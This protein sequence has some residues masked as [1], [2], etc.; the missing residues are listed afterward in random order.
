M[1]DVITTQP[2]A[3]PRSDS[4]SSGE[5]HQVLTGFPL[6]TRLQRQG[7][8]AGDRPYDPETQSVIGSPIWSVPDRGARSR[9]ARWFFDDSLVSGRGRVDVLHDLVETQAHRQVPDFAEVLPERAKSHR[10]VPCIRGRHRPAISRSQ[11][12]LISAR[13]GIKPPGCRGGGEFLIPHS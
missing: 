5:K 13:P 1:Y 12:K 9:A 8:N 3:T 6:P 2:R 4:R 11:S 7:I 10:S